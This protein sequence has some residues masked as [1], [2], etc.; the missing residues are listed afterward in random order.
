MAVLSKLM[1]GPD[2]FIACPYRIHYYT[3][4]VMHSRYMHGQFIQVGTTC[5]FLKS[6]D[7]KNGPGGLLVRVQ[8]N[9]AINYG[10]NLNM[11]IRTILL[12]KEACL[13]GVIFY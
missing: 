9:P 1:Q 5:T 8:I 13:F 7:G 3:M 11:N 4:R 6:K 2:S 10:I 12:T